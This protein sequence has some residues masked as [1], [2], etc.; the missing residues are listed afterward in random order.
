MHK[1]YTCM[2]TLPYTVLYTC[3]YN[4]F[5]TAHASTSKQKQKPKHETNID[6][7][8]EMKTSDILIAPFDI[9]FASQGF[10]IHFAPLVEKQHRV[11]RKPL[12]CEDVFY[13]KANEFKLN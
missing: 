1:N 9:I 13:I 11:D 4:A 2:N 10:T 6:R 12:V 3:I 7:E 8:V 5:S